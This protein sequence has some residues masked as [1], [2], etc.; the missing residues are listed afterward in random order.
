MQQSLNKQIHVGLTGHH[1]HQVWTCLQVVAGLLPRYLKAHLFTHCN[2][3]NAEF[4]SADNQTCQLNRN[5]H[6]IAKSS[7]VEKSVRRGRH[8]YLKTWH[9]LKDFLKYKSILSGTAQT[10]KT[11]NQAL[12]GAVKIVNAL[13]K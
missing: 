7:T 6:Y 1:T 4:W 10:T 11:N 2:K 3:A 9:S 12:N 13:M 5:R 8:K